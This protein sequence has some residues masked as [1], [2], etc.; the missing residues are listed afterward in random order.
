[1]HAVE[2]SLVIAD[3]RRPTIHSLVEIVVIKDP[4]QRIEAA[5]RGGGNE[6]GDYAVTPSN[7]PAPENRGGS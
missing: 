3:Q 5:Q 4:R 2:V 7:I 6:R 1:M